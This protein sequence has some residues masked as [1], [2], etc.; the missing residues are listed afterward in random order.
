MPAQFPRL[1]SQRLNGENTRYQ[2]QGDFRCAGEENCHVVELKDGHQ[3]DTK[4]ASAERRAIHSFIE[5]NAQYL[6]YR[7]SAHFCCFNQDS[8]EAIVTGFK[9]KITQDE[10][11][12]GREFC[13]LLEIDY[14]EIVSDRQSEQP[15]N[16]RFFL[17]E[18]TRIDQ[19]KAILRELL[20]NGHG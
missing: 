19:V 15:T 9:N 16:V 10:A 12:T 18:L 11:M 17:R 14:D 1:R 20:S 4:K 2:N 7:I 8:R 6:Q 5:R 13:A 3:F